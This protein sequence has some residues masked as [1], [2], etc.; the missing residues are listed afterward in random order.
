MGE[1]VDEV[2]PRCSQLG[3]RRKSV[4]PGELRGAAGID[5]RLLGRR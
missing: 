2:L 5:A 4:E 1:L 3:M